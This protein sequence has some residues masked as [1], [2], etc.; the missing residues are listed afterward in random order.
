MHSICLDL[1]TAWSRQSCFFTYLGPQELAAENQGGRKEE[2]V[3]DDQPPI[4]DRKEAVSSKENVEAKTNLEDPKGENEFML[5]GFDFSTGVSICQELALDEE[6]GSL[7]VEE[8]NA[9]FSDEDV[10]DP[11]QLGNALLKALRVD[12]K[13]GSMYQNTASNSNTGAYSV[14]RVCSLSSRVFERH[15]VGSVWEWN[16]W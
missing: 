11:S 1:K 10:Q 14:M 9:L 8:S 3:V 13:D 7:D 16:V 4:E 6:E 5:D 15:L 12:K 2:V